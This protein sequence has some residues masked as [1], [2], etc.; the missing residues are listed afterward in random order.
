MQLQVAAPFTELGSWAISGNGGWGKSR[1]LAF[2]VTAKELD[3]KS[4]KHPYKTA[5]CL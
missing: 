3:F 4:P 2:A 1:G 5:M